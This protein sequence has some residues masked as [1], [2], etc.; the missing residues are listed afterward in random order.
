MSAQRISPP[1]A[2]TPG[3]P[4]LTV[5]DSLQLAHN[6]MF[7]SAQFAVQEEQYTHAG[8]DPQKSYMPDF[9]LAATTAGDLGKAFWGAK[10][11]VA[12][13]CTKDSFEKMA[14]VMLHLTTTHPTITDVT[15]VYLAPADNI[16]EPN[17]IASALA[18]QAL[19][20]VNAVRI[21]RA[22]CAVS[23]LW[24]AQQWVPRAIHTTHLSR[25]TT[26]RPKFKK[27]CMMVPGQDPTVDWFP[28]P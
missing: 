1:Q 23:R 21:W 18:V 8:L 24:H 7:E 22:N 16:D 13:V 27:F 19:C 15:L 25:N 10:P 11:K 14:K 28:A 17:F 6:V 26:R 3:D 12:M 5:T 4:V 2:V 20:P 9:V